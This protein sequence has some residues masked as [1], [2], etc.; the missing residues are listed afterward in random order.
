MS[1]VACP[2]ISDVLRY[3][4]FESRQLDTSFSEVEAT[5]VYKAATTA[6][7]AKSTCSAN[8]GS[9]L[10]NFRTNRRRDDPEKKSRKRQ[11]RVSE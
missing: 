7:E 1:N 8:S 10:R 11:N 3:L 4:E 2:A 5:S 9:G 6:S